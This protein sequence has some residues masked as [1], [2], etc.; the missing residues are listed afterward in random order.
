MNARNG[1]TALKAPTQSREKSA[2]AQHPPGRV[3]SGYVIKQLVADGL[4]SVADAE[5]F[6]QSGGRERAG[7]PLVVLAEMNYRSP[8]ADRQLLD[9]EF[10]TRWLAE[11][12]SLPYFHIDPLKVDFTRVVDVM[13][14]SYATTYSILPV[15]IGA[16]E[17]TIATS[18]PFWIGWEREIEQITKK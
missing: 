12:A 11:K 8:R 9:L 2:G 16:S 7:H 6:K 3:N 15:A 13:S 18:E 14:A 1:V 4:L 10:L 17:V 5:R